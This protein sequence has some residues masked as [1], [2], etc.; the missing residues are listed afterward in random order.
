VTGKFA[1]AVAA[2]VGSVA[3][4]GSVGVPGVVAA[5]A[6]SASS[7]S[8]ASSGKASV[9]VGDNF[10]KPDALEV[11]VGTRVTW[12]NKGR[13]LHN[14]RP[15]KGKWGTK[16]LTK[17]KKYSYTFKKPGEYRYYCSFHG[18]PSSGQRGVIVV[19]DV[20]STTATSNSAASTATTSPTR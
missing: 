14:V 16:S 9:E 13:I 12:T 19:T 11:P 8:T 17:G 6:T 10:F 7:T 2:A 18:S 15:V 1:R 4:A 5:G 20:A 3:L